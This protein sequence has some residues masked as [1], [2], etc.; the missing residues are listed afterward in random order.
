MTSS[1]PLSE[2]TSRLSSSLRTMK[3]SEDDDDDFSFVLGGNVRRISLDLTAPGP[4]QLLHTALTASIYIK[5]ASALD[6]QVKKKRN[7]IGVPAC[8][9]ST[10]A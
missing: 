2:E 3:R 9:K 6:F 8:Y 10:T 4:S 1:F 5:N 7:P